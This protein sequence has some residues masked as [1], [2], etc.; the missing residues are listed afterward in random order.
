MILV[1]KVTKRYK[2]VSNQIRYDANNNYCNCLHQV[3]GVYEKS[4]V[5]YGGCRIRKVM[6]IYSV[7]T[8]S[9]SGPKGPQA[10]CIIF[11]FLML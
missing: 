3:V 9:L 6:L 2:S 5:L 4:K 8:S 7:R 1:I 11:N 10:F